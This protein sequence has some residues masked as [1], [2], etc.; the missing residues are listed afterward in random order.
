MPESFSYPQVEDNYSVSPVQSISPM[1][2]DSPN[3]PPSPLAD[4]TSLIVGR[5]FG[6]DTDN[7]AHHM[8]LCVYPQVEDTCVVEHRP[9]ADAAMEDVPLG[10]DV[11]ESEDATEVEWALRNA[12]IGG[13]KD[14]LPA[15]RSSNDDEDEEGQEHHGDARMFDDLSFSGV[16]CSGTSH[17][18][19]SNPAECFR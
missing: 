16:G 9:D 3:L 14:A 7:D 12:S 19:D 10:S 5:A 4:W 8:Q 17:E 18:S 13:C 15:L 2:T 11:A 1:Q 6:F